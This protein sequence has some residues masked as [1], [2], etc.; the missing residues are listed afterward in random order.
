MRF[1]SF[2]GRQYDKDGNLHNW[3]TEEAETKF[4]ERAQCLVDQ[5]GSFVSPEAGLNVS[6]VKL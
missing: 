3:W 2:L 1:L 5:Y 4:H 6:A